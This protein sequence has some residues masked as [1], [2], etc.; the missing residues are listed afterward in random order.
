MREFLNIGDRLRFFRETTGLNQKEF[1]EKCGIT[2]QSL[3]K[4]ENNSN[5]ISDEAKICLFHEGLNINW[6]LAGVG[7]MQVKHRPTGTF[8]EVP[9]LTKE[10]VFS[11]SIIKETAAHTGDYP[12]KILIPVSDRIREFSTDL[13]ALRVFNSRMAPTLS[14]GDIALFEGSGWNG[15]GIYVYINNEELHISRIQFTQSGYELT[16]EFKP[17]ETIEYVAKNF[18]II[19]R[20]R[21]VLKEVL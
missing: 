13:R 14:A 7:E 19:G 20:I 2:Q 9:L 10:E 4:Y 18:S 17:E 15:D 3:S 21:A 8:Y 1:A 5:A 6:L 11:M 12:E 16:K